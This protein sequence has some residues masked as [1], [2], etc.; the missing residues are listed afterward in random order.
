MDGTS[1]AGA[2]PAEPGGVDLDAAQLAEQIGTLTEAAR[3]GGGA[4]ARS[5]LLELRHLL[6]VRRLERP[7]SGAPVP[8]PDPSR[9]RTVDGLPHIDPG[10][11]SAGTLRAAILAGGCAV[12]PGLVDE[13]LAGELAEE[14]DQAFA[15]RDRL[16]VGQEADRSYYSP[17]AVR[18]PFKAPL[19]PWIKKATGLLAADSPHLAFELFEAYERAGVLAL[20]AAYLGDDVCMAVDK[21]T[22]RMV[23]PSPSG[24]AWHQ[25][26]SFMGDVRSM[27]VWL[28]LSHAG[29]DAPGL[30]IVPRRLDGLVATG[31]EGTFLADQVSDAV[32]VK[33]AG[34]LAVVRP[35]VRP[36]DAVIFDELC[37][38]RTGVD[39]SMTR[40]R[41]AI[42]SWFFSPSAFPGKYAPLAV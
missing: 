4:S 5:R 13:G 16:D 22:F 36:G 23:A 34:D 25:D 30:D 40:T 6:G 7:E 2:R 26:G 18:P 24:G 17:L 12:V 41:Y 1:A 37:L 32:A 10:D 9:V 27:N 19:R 39:P 3:R 8:E 42:E 31:T 21:T 35:V 33:A 38:H 11:L 20:A 14:I 28:S 29:V 15:A